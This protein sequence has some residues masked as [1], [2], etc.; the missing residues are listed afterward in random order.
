MGLFAELHSSRIRWLQVLNG[1]IKKYALCH[2]I[3]VGPDKYERLRFGSMS[4]RTLGIAEFIIK[5][6]D[7]KKEYRR[8]EVLFRAREDTPR[9]RGEN[10]LPVGWWTQGPPYLKQKR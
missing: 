7:L 8:L 6:K 9:K 1:A 3:R 10:F 5:I 2:E 4:S